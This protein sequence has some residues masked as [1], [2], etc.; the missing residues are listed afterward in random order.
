MPNQCSPLGA[1]S[2]SVVTGLAVPVEKRSSIFTNDPALVSSRGGSVV[3][4]WPTKPGRVKE[5][6]ELQSFEGRPRAYLPGQLAKTFPPMGTVTSA[7]GAKDFGLGADPVELLRSAKPGNWHNAMLGFTAHCISAGFPD[8]IIIEAA[9]SFL[10]DPNDPR[11][12]EILIA[13]ARKKFAKP[14]PDPKTQGD[15]PVTAIGLKSF[16]LLDVSSGFRDG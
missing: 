5:M 6:V 9:R 4:K 16:R 1:A 12:L 3:I 15:T 2:A 13:G 14:N 11:D 8:W 7:S 10:D